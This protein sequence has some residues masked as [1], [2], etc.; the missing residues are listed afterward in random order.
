MANLIKTPRI[1]MSTVRLNQMIE[2][3]SRVILRM[4]R[5]ATE[6][7]EVYIRRS[8]LYATLELYEDAHTDAL[9]AIELWLVVSSAFAIKPIEL[10]FFMCVQIIYL[11]R[12]GG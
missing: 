10:T 3:Y 5:H 6:V 4:K 1:S 9:R 8:A 11:Q 12:K 7:S 2:N